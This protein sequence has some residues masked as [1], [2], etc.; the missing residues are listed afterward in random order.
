MPHFRRWHI[1]LIP[2][3]AGKP[4]LALDWVNRAISRQPHVPGWYYLHRG[5]AYYGNGDC[6]RAVAEFE[7]IPWLRNQM[8]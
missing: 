6:K 4:D 2:I 3:Y 8:S 1:A 7:N 5:L